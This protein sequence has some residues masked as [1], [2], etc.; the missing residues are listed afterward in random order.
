[1][2]AYPY[3]IKNSEEQAKPKDPLGIFAFQSLKLSINKV[4]VY[5]IMYI[6]YVICI[7]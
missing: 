1:M 3:A 4:A 2:E 6:I 7:S 5:C